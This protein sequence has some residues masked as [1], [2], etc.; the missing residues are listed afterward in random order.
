MIK[1]KHL[2]IITHQSD[3][4]KLSLK[5]VE[6]LQEIGISLHP[7][8]A[9]PYEY[10]RESKVILMPTT[11]GE[12]LSRVLLEAS[13]IGIPILATKIKGIE[14]ILPK[15]YQYFIKSNKCSFS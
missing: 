13:Y 6:Y 7:Y 3:I 14:D 8:L 12:G 15:G 1:K 11:Y 2:R 9:D 10:Y 5:E 4:D